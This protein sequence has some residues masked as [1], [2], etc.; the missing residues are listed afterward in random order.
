MNAAENFETNPARKNYFFIL[1][2]ACG[3]GF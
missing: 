2:P 1:H 3:V